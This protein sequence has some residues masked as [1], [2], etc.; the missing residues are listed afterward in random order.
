MGHH[1]SIIKRLEFS[2]WMLKVPGFGTAN[3]TLLRISTPG[4]GTWQARDSYGAITGD[5]YLQATGRGGAYEEKG[6]LHKGNWKSK[7][8]TPLNVVLHP[9]KNTQTRTW[10]QGKISG[11]LDSLQARSLLEDSPITQHHC[12]RLM[13]RRHIL[14]PLMRRLLKWSGYIKWHAQDLPGQLSLKQGAKHHATYPDSGKWRS[15]HNFLPYH[16]C[17]ITSQINGTRYPIATANT[18]CFEHDDEGLREH[19]AA[20]WK[21]TQSKSALDHYTAQSWSMQKVLWAG[22]SIVLPSVRSVCFLLSG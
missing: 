22:Q 16:L 17:V 12:I 8:W 13:S 1:L 4:K 11:C 7:W 5:V 19:W 15:K 6:K 14:S 3:A 18:V 10:L 21:R 2:K 20:L 9:G